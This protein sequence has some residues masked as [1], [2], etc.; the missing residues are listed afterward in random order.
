MKNRAIRICSGLLC[1]LL[2]FQPCQPLHVLDSVI[3]ARR[4]EVVKFKASQWDPFLHSLN[5]SLDSDTSVDPRCLA[6][7]RLFINAMILRED[8]GL[9][10]LDSQGSMP[11]GF[12]RG[13][14]LEMGSHKQCFAA[15]LTD[16]SGAAI[17]RKFCMTTVRPNGPVP[18][19]PQIPSHQ[20]DVAQMFALEH[21]TIKVGAC[22]PSACSNEDIAGILNKGMCTDSPGMVA[23]VFITVLRWLRCSAP[24]ITN[25]IISAIPG[26]GHLSG[27]QAVHIELYMSV[28]LDVFFFH[29]PG[30][31]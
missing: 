21:S 25:K 17:G 29:H 2:S 12:L 24:S 4:M 22:Y 5:A 28:V 16:E 8:S 11:A 15:D 3:K 1:F 31:N 9:Q 27:R 23:V 6:D 13:S 26:V 30:V 19:F 14:L 10:L 7:M 20:Q 18:E